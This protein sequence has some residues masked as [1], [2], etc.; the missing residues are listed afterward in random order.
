MTDLGIGFPLDFDP[1]QFP[2]P[3]CLPGPQKSL[4][5]AAESNLLTIET[6]VGGTSWVF[7]TME[8]VEGML[9]RMKLSEAEKKGIQIGGGDQGKGRMKEAQAIGKL[10]SDKCV[11]AEVVQLALERVWC[12][13]K[14]M[15]VK[16][17]GENHFLFTFHQ[18]SGRA[19]ALE[20][21]P[22]MVSRDLMVVTEFDGSK[23]L[24]EI[25]F[26]SVPIWVR[27]MK[28][29]LGMMMDREIA[30]IL[31]EEIGSYMDVDLEENHSDVGCFLRV[32]IRLDITKPLMR[33]VTITV[34]GKDRWCPLVYEFLPDFC[35]VCGMIGH[36]DKSCSVKLAKGELPQFD[37]K[38][39]FIP[40]K[41]RG[42]HGVV[43]RNSVLRGA[44]KP[45]LHRDSGSRWG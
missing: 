38:L 1:V 24:E 3:T 9:R 29:P 21:G 10:L 22:W 13:I 44:C 30:V 6:L 2:R 19:K 27:I 26:T 8:G 5:R 20:E 45:G 28:L 33:G 40:Q 43:S 17:L 15:E 32:K 23:I 41:R 12:P 4:C 11:S 39:R 36:L 16:A 37:K 35:Y 14:G 31:G 42:V 7:T 18:V 34:D 25:T